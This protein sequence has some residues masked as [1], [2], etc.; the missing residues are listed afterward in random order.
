MKKFA[1]FM[2][3][4]SILIMVSCNKNEK[5]PDLKGE[6]KTLH[7][8]STFSINQLRSIGVSA[9]YT[10]GG[11]NRNQRDL[12]MNWQSDT[13]DDSANKPKLLI[14]VGDNV[15]EV[16]A[17]NYTYT[18]SSTGSS[19]VR[20]K[21]D[22]VRY[23]NAN[24]AVLIYLF[25]KTVS[26]N[27]EAATLSFPDQNG[28]SI[29]PINGGG[30][31]NFNFIFKASTTV[32]NIID[33]RA[34]QLMPLGTVILFDMEKE[35][36]SG[37][38]ITVTSDAFDFACDVDLKSGLNKTTSGEVSKTYS[39]EHGTAEKS[40]Y[41]LYCLGRE[42]TDK[43]IGISGLFGTTETKKYFM[44]QSPAAYSGKFINLSTIGDSEYFVTEWQGG[45]IGV[46]NMTSANINNAVVQYRE[47]GTEKWIKF[48]P[49]QSFEI[50][51]PDQSKTYELRITGIETFKVASDKI[52]KVTQWGSIKWKNLD[53]TFKG[54]TNLDVVA[55]DV[56]DLSVCTSCV[57]TF[58]GC[59][60]LVGNTQ[61]NNWDVSNVT[62]MSGMFKTAWK[63]NQP[64]SN[65]SVSN[66]TD[67]SGMFQ[68]ARAF[69]QNIESWK[70]GS[71]TNMQNMFS[72][73]VK[74]NQPLNNWD[75]SSVTNM[76]FMFYSAEAFNKPLDKWKVDNVTT[77]KCMFNYASA[78]NKPLNTWKVDNVTDMESLFD[79]AQAFNQPLNNWKTTKVTNLK[80]TFANAT[81]FNGDI[82]TWDVS[83]VTNMNQTFNGARSFNQPIGGW[84]TSKVT[85]MFSMFGGASIFNQPL[86]DWDVSN[87][88]NMGMMFSDASEFNYPLDKWKVSKVE[89]M[90]SMF[91]RANK[92][93]Q[94][95]S[96]WD[97]AKVTSFSG[98]FEDC[99][100]TTDNKPQKFR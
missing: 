70:T 33:R 86:N 79:N 74:F 35:A 42:G 53:N 68:S 51:V 34:S 66:V 19:S 25:D 85:N 99:P 73:A 81:S 32:Q 75:V 88:T 80:Y 94:N 65:W 57:E 29:A 100:I 55:Q 24:D 47:K 41:A 82:S 30:N 98:I 84:K 18:K 43:Y 64:L 87:V 22:G 16:P 44:A 83:N 58:S 50:T 54:C 17:E 11:D 61:F 4:L 9:D 6:T 21:Y 59:N 31:K 28:T 8:E 15:Y 62:N 7:I 71:V 48:N 40:I 36:T 26:Y 46:V 12:S 90:G 38:Q 67:M 72:G 45:N 56:P 63:F 52:K 77:M 5:M 95:I 3:L 76:N 60:V 10:A 69:N 27:K 1:L 96:N 91:R 89:N 49:S 13:W 37:K 97:V 93:N 39:I 78:F 2:S 20:I 14:A 92:F 23:N